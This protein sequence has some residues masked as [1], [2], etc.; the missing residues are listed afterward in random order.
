MPPKLSRRAREVVL[1][2]VEER[3]GFPRVEVLEMVRS[4]SDS[5]CLEALEVHLSSL[6]T[7]FIC[8]DSLSESRVWYVSEVHTKDSERSVRRLSDLP[9]MSTYLDYLK[10]VSTTTTTTP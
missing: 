3:T 7:Y 4:L 8:L 5:E 10:T 9:F 2:T 1:I 6:A